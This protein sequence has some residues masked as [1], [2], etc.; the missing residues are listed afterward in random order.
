MIES[1]PFLISGVLLG[2]AA[3]ISPGPL[4]TLV[5]SET[6]RHGKRGGV[7]IASAPIVTDVPIV[8]ISVFILAKMQN[9]TLVLGIISLS[10]AVFIAFLAYESISIKGIELNL[11]KVRAQSLRRGII[12]NLLSPHPYLFWI[13]IGA[14]FLLKGYRTN[15]MSVVFF[16]MGFYL[17]LVGSKITIALIVDKYKLF[18]K[19]NAY[20]YIVKTLGL[21]LLVFSALFLK[22]GLTLLG[23]LP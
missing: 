15:V 17:F 9:F 5:I 10:G 3:G 11:G 7:L 18:L 2:A 22:D 21:I 12:T 8:A 16:L 1:L 4:L 14:P 19:S 6:L 13:T 20:V 23:I